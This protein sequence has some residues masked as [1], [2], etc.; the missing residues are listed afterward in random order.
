MRVLVSI[1]LLAWFIQPTIGMADSINL[2]A[3]ASGETQRIEGHLDSLA[4]LVM[5]ASAMIVA[6]LLNTKAAGARALG[7]AMAAVLCAAVAGW[8]FLFV[9][10][11]GILE[12]PKPNQT[13]LD[14]AKP[15]LL[16]GQAL[17]A[18]V[19]A[20]WLALV[21]YRQQRDSKVLLLGRENEADRYGQ[22]SRF[23]H[24][25]IAILF[26][27]LIPMG[28]FASIIPEGTSFRNAYYVVHKTIGV[29]VIGLVFVRLVWNRLSPRP[30][31][32]AALKP[33][34]RKLAKFAHGALYVAM[35]AVPITGF[36]MT[37]FHGYPTF[38]FAWEFGPFWASSDSATIAWGSFHKYLLPTLVYLILG[39][40]IAGALKHRF[41]DGH[42]QAF[43]RIVG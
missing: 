21:A 43:R 4:A 7:T 10:T 26:I 33:T 40:H 30:A 3:G 13:P 29:V 24:W 22:V 12:N 19:A 25:T 14:S 34:E 32:N 5:L 6:G 16:L 35:V 31:L 37:S 23:L 11:T 36:V 39:A 1:T 42:K 9:M 27:A 28:I 20:A 38:F 8:F 15:A 17:I 41:I 2:A 18:A